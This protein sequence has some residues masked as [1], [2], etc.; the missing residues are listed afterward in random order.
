V[1]LYPAP[2]KLNLFLHVLGRRDDGYHRLQSVF[3]FIDLCDWI[4]IEA[5]A[6][7]RILRVGDN[8]GIPEEQDLALRATHLLKAHSGSGMG[9]AIGVEKHI[10]L[11]GGL[12]GGSSNAATV[13]CVLNRLWN[14]GMETA[15]LAQIGL[16]LGADVPVFVHGRNAWAEGVGEV[17]TPIE[18]PP[19][20]YVLIHP[21]VSVSTKA[22][23]AAPELTRS[24]KPLK[25]QAF[26]V[27]PSGDRFHNDLEPVVRSKFPQVA[28]AMD[29]LKAH[30]DAR[31]SGSG[32]C[33][34][35]AFPSEAE[36]RSVAQRIPP[37]WRG[38]AVQGLDCHPLKF[39]ESVLVGSRQ[40]G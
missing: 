11:G 22:I 35:A 3:R 15:E 36:A 37:E 34:F 13:L 20:W 31:M 38:F 19:S 6:D 21:G 8:A 16:R 27:G 9:A 30:G 40:A 17:L 33:V 4:G 18:I 28:R 25:I 24:T 12:G 7:G 39:D 10:P 32:A 29:W 14:L 26:S 1:K 2:A 23:F 5:R